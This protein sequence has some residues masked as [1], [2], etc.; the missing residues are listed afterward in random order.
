[1]VAGDGFL[2]DV[3]GFTVQTSCGYAVPMITESIDEAM[4]KEGPKAYMKDRETLG[5]FAKKAVGKGEMD[6]YRQTKN[7]RSLDGCPGLKVARRQKGEYLLL[8]DGLAWFRRVGRQWDAILLGFVLAMLMMVAMRGVPG[9]GEFS[10]RLPSAVK[11][12][13]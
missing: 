2:A 9:L 4:V 10:V 7:V 12:M 5:H 3:S 11:V 13:G 6:F 8:E 1:M